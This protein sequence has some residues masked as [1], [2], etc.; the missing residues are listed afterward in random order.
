MVILPHTINTHEDLLQELG[1]NVEII[2]REQISYNHVK[3]LATKANI[4]LMDDLA[5]SLDVKDT[6][7]QKPVSL[8]NSLGIKMVSKLK[9]MSG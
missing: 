9:K 6:F 5:F 1:N 8:L 4:M 7:A 2:C 3:R